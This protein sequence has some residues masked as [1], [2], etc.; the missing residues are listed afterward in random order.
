MLPSMKE[1]EKEIARAGELNP[2]LWIEH[3]INVGRAAR[4]IADKCKEINPEKA[5]ILGILHDVGRR[6]GIVSVRHIYEGYQYMTEKGWDEV[7][8]VCLTHSYPVQDI[9]A[10]IGK[11]DLTKEEYDFTDKYIKTVTYDDYDKLIIL[12][13]ALATAEGFCLLEKRFVDTTRR[14][15]IFPFT[16]DRWNATFKIKEDFEKQTGCSIYNLLPNIK[17]TTFL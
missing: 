17:E 5:Y 9:T 15:G 11:N 6:V 8:K 2:G 10:D 12:C 7:A 13:D 4:L 3:S 16:V 1:A 14:Y